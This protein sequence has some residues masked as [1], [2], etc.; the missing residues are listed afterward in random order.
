MMTVGWM[1]ALVV[2]AY[3]GTAWL[4]YING[5]VA[6]NEGESR[7]PWLVAVALLAALGVNT[8]LRADVFLTELVRET[9]KLEFWY[10][11]RSGIQYM[12]FAALSVVMLWLLV[13]LKGAFVASE[14]SEETIPTG[15]L[16]LVL[17]LG[18]RGISWHLTD[19][20]INE[21]VLGVS[22]GRWA[23]LFFLGMVSSGAWRCLQRR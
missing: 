17:L 2:A 20:F 22:L 18:T 16:L 19:T 5:F 10:G 12:A 9:A 8:L 6:K 13:R 11:T 1:H 15:L 3:F 21:R 7:G 14:V 4:C 23:E